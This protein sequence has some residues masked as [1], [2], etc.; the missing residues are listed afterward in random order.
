ME[1]DYVIVGAG[2]A[3]CV[4]AARLTEDANIRVLVLEAGGMD[5]DPMIKVPLTWAKMFH[6]RSH[7]WGYDFEPEQ[8]TGGRAI[9][10]ARVI[11]L[12]NRPTG[13]CRA[14]FPDCPQAAVTES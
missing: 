4:L 13:G 12:E 5:T 7:D 6:D 10:C 2:S 9:E 11:V 14:G 8:T 3:G 1:F